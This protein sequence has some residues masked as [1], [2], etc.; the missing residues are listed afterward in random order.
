MLSGDTRITP[1]RT[2]L[3]TSYT[4][5]I[6]VTAA[7]T[8]IHPPYGGGTITY[9]REGPF[10]LIHPPDGGAY[11]WPDVNGDGALLLSDDASAEPYYDL[12]DCPALDGFDG[13]S[14]FCVEF[15]FKLLADSGSDRYIFHSTGEK[16]AG[17]SGR[18]Q[19]LRISVQSRR[20]AVGLRTSSGS[21]LF[22]TVGQVLA[23]NTE[24]D[25]AVNYNGTTIQVF[26][27]GSQVSSQAH[28]GTV[29][30]E[31]WESWWLGGSQSQAFGLTELQPGPQ[32][33]IR[34]IRISGVSRRTANYTPP[35]SFPIG[36]AGDLWN[37]MFSVTSGPCLQYWSST[38]F[39]WLVGYS[40]A[41]GSLGQTGVEIGCD[42]R[43]LVVSGSAGL[44]M[45]RSVGGVG[46][47]LRRLRSTTGRYGIHA[48]NNSFELNAFDCEFTGSSGRAGVVNTIAS[49]VNLY[50]RVRI[51]GGFTAG[52]A[53]GVGGVIVRGGWH[54]P[55]VLSYWAWADAAGTDIYLDGVTSSS[56]GIDT[57]RHVA[58]VSNVGI[59]TQIGGRVDNEK[60]EADVGYSWGAELSGA[61]YVLRGIHIRQL[62]GS[63]NIQSPVGRASFTDCYFN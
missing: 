41:F 6:L 18:T 19:A 57:A 45:V 11:P 40:E 32:A 9:Q 51:A 60:D 1:R 37:S 7:S 24:H 48:T 53:L 63:G 21:A 43:E 30:Q 10:I 5:P 47:K 14:A 62:D 31:W 8:V 20:I 35:A 52:F 25:I 61:K 44:Q 46:A 54:V 58:A 27:D 15:K 50:E 39:G 22:E 42:D 56:E 33:R 59:F 12:S 16:L 13:L 2:I 3:R 26:V 49:G 29:I 38:G 36:N 28:T 34:W 55:G 4:E 23:V 17:S